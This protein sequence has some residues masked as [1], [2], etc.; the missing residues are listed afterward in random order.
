MTFF[1]ST[2][3]HTHSFIGSSEPFAIQEIALELREKK[4][5]H[6]SK[7]DLISKF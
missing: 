4:N 3:T 1:P 7:Q 6:L 5:K 2:H